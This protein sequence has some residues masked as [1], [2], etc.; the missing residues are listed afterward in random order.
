MATAITKK[1]PCSTCQ[2]AA[3]ILTC[4]GCA[5][6]FCYRHVGEHRQELSKQMDE[7]TTQHDQ[8]QQTIAD[9]EKQP[10]CHS[11]IEKIGTWEQ[12][13]IDKIHQAAEDARKQVLNIIGTSR[14]LVRNDLANLTQELNKARNEDDYVETDLKEWT[15]KLDKLKT[16]LAAAQTIDFGQDD[17][18][19]SLISKI[20]INA[21]LTDSFYQITGDMQISENGR[22]VVHGPANQLAAARCGGEYSVGQHRFRFKIDQMYNYNGFS[23]GIISKSIPVGS[24][25][26]TV[27]NY[28]Y[29]PY[30]G[31]SGISNRLNHNVLISFNDRN[32][33]FLINNTYELLIDCNQQKMRL[34]NECLG[35]TQ[36]LPVNLTTCPFPWQF[37][38][39]LYYA[40]DRA[41]LC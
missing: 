30:P 36:E 31:G 16:D 2:K 26:I 14:T 32:C 4:R 41:S 1:T 27:P 23:C 24:I 18:K 29:E 5:K 11:L 25:F 19:I 22:N 33:N 13:S 3:G 7:V 20:Y 21:A 40:N 37:F 39:T 38:I 34:T 12:Q 28:T 10:N 8:L 15:E 9:Q 6:D 17:D 35:R